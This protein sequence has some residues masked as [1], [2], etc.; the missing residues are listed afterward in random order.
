MVGA[1]HDHLGDGHAEVHFVRR[2][3][4][5][6]EESLQQRTQTAEL[7]HG[8]EVELHLRQVGEA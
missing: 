2:Q 7:G 4:L 8:R 1:E 6:D 5:A 3:S